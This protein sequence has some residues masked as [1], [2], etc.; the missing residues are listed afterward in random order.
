M[1]LRRGVTGDQISATVV[2]RLPETVVA[3]GAEPR[4]HERVEVTGAEEEQVRLDVA[5]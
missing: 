3:G 1:K 5:G 4:Q 2:D